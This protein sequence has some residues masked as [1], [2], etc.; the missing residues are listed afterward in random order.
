MLEI[1][2]LSETTKESFLNSLRQVVKELNQYNDLYSKAYREF[3]NELG[4]LLSNSDDCDSD[5]LEAR[6][7]SFMGLISEY[8]LDKEMK[9]SEYLLEM[10]EVE[11]EDDI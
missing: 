7:L 3:F 11:D 10:E 9:Y 6:M 1:L 8:L 4:K 2:P 5:E